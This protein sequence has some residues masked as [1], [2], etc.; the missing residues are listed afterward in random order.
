MKKTEIKK[1]IKNF[2]RERGIK[3][4]TLSVYEFLEMTQ[5]NNFNFY[6]E[7]KTNDGEGWI[8]A[9]IP[10][11]INGRYGG[12]IFDCD[13]GLEIDGD[14]SIDE[15]VETILKYQEDVENLKK[16]FLKVISFL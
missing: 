8:E 9:I 3:G 14:L 12:I 7:W 11:E 5:Q 13:V 4:K 6:F 15:A 1:I 10:I 2:M 16:E